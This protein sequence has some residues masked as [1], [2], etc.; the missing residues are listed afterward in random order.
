[1]AQ[2][3]QQIIDTTN[4][5]STGLGF[6][7]PLSGNAVFN[8]TYTTRDV[9]RANLI[10][11][12]LTNKGERVMRPEFGANLREL[13][14]EGITEG[15]EDILQERITDQVAIEFPMV[16]VVSTTFLKSDDNNSINFILEYKVKNTGTIDE[17]NI[18]LNT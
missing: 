13:I 5:G 12:I 11:W 9:V 14:F 10:N 8:P 1:M 16:D 18:E 6:S 4:T 7:F 15:S 3:I 2:I 17:L